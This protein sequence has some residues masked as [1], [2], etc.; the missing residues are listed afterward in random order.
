MHEAEVRSLYF[1]AL[2]NRYTRQKQWIVGLSFFL[3]SGAALSAFGSLVGGW[4]PGILGSMVAILTAYSIAANL[5][6]KTAV[7]LKLHQGWNQLHNEYSRVRQHWFED[8]AERDFES[9]LRRAGEFS[10]E[11]SV[12]TPWNPKLMA[13]WEKA[14]YAK[15]SANTA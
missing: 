1:A 14:V 6:Q 12:S 7:C 5:D 15:F 4:L 10:G 11:A 3:S 9:L 2:A 8:S 13:H